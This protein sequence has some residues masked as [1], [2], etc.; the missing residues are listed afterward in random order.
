MQV[1]CTK[2][3]SPDCAH[4]RRTS[5]RTRVT[6][7]ACEGVERQVGTKKGLVPLPRTQHRTAEDGECALE[8]EEPTGVQC[9]DI[10]A[11]AC[12][13]LAEKLRIPYAYFERMRTEQPELLDGDLN[14]RPAREKG[15]RQ[16][17]RKLDGGARGLVGAL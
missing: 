9:Y 8:I 17:L 11:L 6:R 14:A 4:A 15:E 3:L 5:T 16:L 7:P 2:A 10:T 12:R 13:Q 1:T